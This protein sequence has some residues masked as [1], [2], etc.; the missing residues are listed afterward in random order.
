MEDS[1]WFAKQFGVFIL[2]AIT[3]LNFVTDGQMILGDFHKNQGMIPE[4]SHMI[5]DCNHEYTL[6][7]VNTLEL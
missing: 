1:L 7:E 5:N 6:N 4:S 2:G 3:K